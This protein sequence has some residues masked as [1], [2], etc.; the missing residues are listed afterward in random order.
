MLV[1]ADDDVGLALGLGQRD[2]AD[3]ALEEAVL[4]GLGVF[5]LR[6]EREDIALLAAELIVAGQVVGGLRHGVGAEQAL[7]LGV[8]EARA[9]RGIEHLEVLAEGLLGLADH[10]RRP[11]HALDAAGDAHVGLAAGDGMRRADQRV[12]ARAAQ[13]V[14]HGAGRLDRQTRQQQRVA[15]DVAAVLAGLARR[16]RPTRRR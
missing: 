12:E 6:A 7:D 9:E 3:L 8:G 5:L 4:V 1:G 15:G 14:V 13:P 10:E 16:S 2:R 11:R